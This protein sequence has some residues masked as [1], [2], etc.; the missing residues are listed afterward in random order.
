[1]CGRALLGR[2]PPAAARFGV[3]WLGRDAIK[4]KAVAFTRQPIAHT[5]RPQQSAAAQTDR[6]QP[7]STSCN[8]HSLVLS[9]SSSLP[10]TCAPRR[11]V[12]LARLLSRRSMLCT[13]ASSLALPT[14][15]AIH[16]RAIVTHDG[17]CA[18]MRGHARHS[19]ATPPPALRTPTHVARRPRAQV[20]SCAT[21]QG[22]TESA[23]PCFE[24]LPPPFGSLV[25]TS[26]CPPG[27]VHVTLSDGSPCLRPLVVPAAYQ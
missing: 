2:A 12:P 9:N 16:T 1:M 11:R 4:R 26:A 22:L 19:H 18:V 17:R 21:P 15:C 24:V 13:N 6:I 10:C 14:A 8:R 25:D 3:L 7:S 23:S 5:S 27:S 20:S